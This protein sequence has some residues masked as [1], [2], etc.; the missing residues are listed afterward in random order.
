VGN[1]LFHYK[2]TDQKTGKNIS[3]AEPLTE[4]ELEEAFGINLQRRKE[5]QILPSEGMKPFRDLLTGMEFVFIHGGC[6]EMGDS[7]W[8]W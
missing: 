1:L 8:R 7:F 2:Y 6:F 5:R 3:S 4:T